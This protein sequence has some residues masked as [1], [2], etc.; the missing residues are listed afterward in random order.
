MRIEQNFE[1]YKKRYYLNENAVF[2]ALV[3]DKTRLFTQKFVKF[4]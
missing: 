1:D 4:I 2:D 3:S